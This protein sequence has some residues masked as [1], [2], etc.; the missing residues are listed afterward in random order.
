MAKAFAAVGV[1]VDLSFVGGGFVGGRV[2]DAADVRV[3]GEVGEELEREEDVLVAELE[4][5]VR[6]RRNRRRARRHRPRSR[7]RSLR[8]AGPLFGFGVNDIH[9]DVSVA[10]DNVLLIV[11]PRP[12]LVQDVKVGPCV[13]LV[14]YLVLRRRLVAL[15]RI[16][17]PIRLL[18]RR[19]GGVVR[20]HRDDRVGR[21]DA[22][23]RGERRR[24]R[25]G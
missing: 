12:T 1:V 11:L 24:R 3:L 16:P 25:G 22:G 15:R 8:T 2:E 17:I 10:I 7:A 19:R 21:A 6:G 23:R 5:L 14:Q 18:S 20:V 13:P 4:C 9:H